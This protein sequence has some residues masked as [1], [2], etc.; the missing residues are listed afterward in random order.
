MELAKFNLE[1]PRSGAKQIVDCEQSLVIVGANGSGKTRLGTWLEQ[2]S[3]EP[4]RERVH[5]ISAQK[6]LAM[7]DSVSTSSLELAQNA[8]L[9]GHPTINQ[10]HERDHHKRFTRL[11]NRPALGMLNDFDKL[12]TYLFSDHMEH[13]AK[14]LAASRLTDQ[15][16][17]PPTT[18]LE[19]IKEVWEATLPH[20]ELILGGARIQTKVKGGLG[21]P[22]SASETSDG[23]RVIFYLLG[24]CIAAP[25]AG[26]IVIDEPELHMHKSIQATFWASVQALRVD[27]LFVYL[28]HDVDFAATLG[29]A[30]KLWLRSFDGRQWEWELVE[31]QAELPDA[32]LLE[33]LGNRKP[34]LFVE[35]DKGSF[36]YSL[37]Q[38]LFPAYLVIPRG[39]CGRVIDAVRALRKSESFHRLQVFGLIDRDRREDRE[40]A[41]L[42]SDGVFVLGVA[43]VENLFCTREVI[44]FLSQKLARD[45]AKDFD[46]ASES[47]IK[48]LSAEIE[49]Q[50]RERAGA[51]IRHSLSAFDSKAPT[52]A[53]LQANLVALLSSIDAEVI[54]R[55]WETRFNDV[56]ARRDYEGLLKIYNRKS[57]ADE[58][59]ATLGLRKN[60][61]QETVIRFAGSDERLNLRSAL[62]H[63]FGGFWRVASASR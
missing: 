5:R 16:V 25:A 51:Q 3:P 45:P 32:L 8:V 6:S 59:G 55:E 40:V 14:Y 24:Q 11:G 60:Q 61:L 56:V 50:A 47:I 1:L 36:D 28:T 48:R 58:V 38:E 15:R 9:Y 52:A 12:L 27:C 20:R 31:R 34:V 19:K 7:P 17:E 49:P 57:L 33:V 21:E 46:A 23:E 37:Y 62:G 13:S 43:E 30:R 18:K 53:A 2:E 54:Q 26:I 41:A 10:L 22:Y 42:E 63:Y 29:A 4:Q 35:G 39:G 44:N